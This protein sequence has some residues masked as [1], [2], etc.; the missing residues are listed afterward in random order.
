MKK[1]AHVQLSFKISLENELMN[2]NSAMKIYG[3]P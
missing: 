1:I 2:S 3:K